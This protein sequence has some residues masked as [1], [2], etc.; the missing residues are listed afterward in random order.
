MPSK[1][2][3]KRKEQR[4]KYY[5]KHRNAEIEKA[6]LWRKENPERNRALKASGNSRRRERHKERQADP[7]YRRRFNE[8][9]LANYYTRNP[10]AGLRDAISKFRSGEFTVDEFIGCISEA[11]VRSDDIV[12]RSR[13]GE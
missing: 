8:R 10:T 4:K 6:T 11:L 9:H 5:E 13:K 7:E 2:P 12:G 1:D 3:Q